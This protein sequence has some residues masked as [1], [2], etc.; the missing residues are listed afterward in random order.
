MVRANMYLTTL[1]IGQ[2]MAQLNHF[3]NIQS[4]FEQKNNSKQEYS[5]G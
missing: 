5:F 1:P 4:C 2:P 3:I